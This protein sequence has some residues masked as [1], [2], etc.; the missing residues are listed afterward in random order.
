MAV[1]WGRATDSGILMCHLAVGAPARGWTTFG[2]ARACCG[3]AFA[4]HPDVRCLMGIIPSS[5]PG[6]FLVAVKA[7][8]RRVAAL[9][10][11]FADGEAAILMARMRDDE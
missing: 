1:V 6:A 11:L 10:G 4:E 8:F 2:L 5:R 3:V 9:P 7:G